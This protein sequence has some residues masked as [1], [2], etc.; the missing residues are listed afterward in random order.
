MLALK[1][2]KVGP[3]KSRHNKYPSEAVDVIPYPFRQ[4][5]WKDR[6]KWHLWIGYVLGIAD[7]LYDEGLMMRR[8]ISGCDWDKDWETSDNEF[9]DFPHLE[10]I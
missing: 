1:L 2:T 3:G 5:D 7:R 10:L 8:V 6:D 4:R 9:D